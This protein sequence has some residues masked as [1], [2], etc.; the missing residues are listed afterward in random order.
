MRLRRD[1]KDRLVTGLIQLLS[2]E[3]SGTSKFMISEAY[4]AMDNH[5]AAILIDNGINPTRNHLKRLEL[6]LCHFG[7]LLAKHE[8]S[9]RSLRGLLKK[10]QDVRYSTARFSP[11]EALSCFRLSHHV[12]R[13]IT[14]YL[15]SKHGRTVERLEIELF[16]EAFG[17]RW[18]GF[19]EQCEYIHQVW[20]Q[21][22][23]DLSERET[24]TRWGGKMLNPSNFCSIGVFAEDE[25]AK[26]ILK[27]KEVATEIADFYQS[28]VKLVVH[29][30]NIRGRYVAGSDDL[31]DFV[32]SLKLSYTGQNV[33][34]TIEDWKRFLSR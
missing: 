3:A 7:T 8:I 27:S 21:N 26:K 31:P 2:A 9:E 20:Q 14:E 33:K 19:E 17:G 24:G 12:I 6:M 30:Q 32:L 23:E 25:V 34:E 16:K 4:L 13:V 28:F 11:N 22:Y 1:V 29:I 15:A 10:W 5:F 18:L